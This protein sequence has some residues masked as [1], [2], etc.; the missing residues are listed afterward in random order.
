VLRAIIWQVTQDHAS[1]APQPSETVL[2]AL[3]LRFVRNVTTNTILQAPRH[4]SR[5]PL[6]CSALRA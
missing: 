1:P 6:I 4:V 5:V 2:F 3:I